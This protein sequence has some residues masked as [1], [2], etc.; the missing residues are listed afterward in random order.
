MKHSHRIHIAFKFSDIHVCIKCQKEMNFGRK[1]KIQ[2]S[3]S[4]DVRRC[5]IETYTNKYKRIS[6][7]LF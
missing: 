2:Y 5:S 1:N 4:S 3:Y 6:G 7:V